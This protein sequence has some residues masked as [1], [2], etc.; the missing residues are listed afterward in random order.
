M[1][2]VCPDAQGIEPA[3][4]QPPMLL[5]ASTSAQPFGTSKGGTPSGVRPPFSPATP[6]AAELSPA[7]A[8]ASLRP[9]EPPRTSAPVDA[10]AISVAA[11]AAG[12][13]NVMPSERFG[14]CLPTKPPPSASAAAPPPSTPARLAQPTFSKLT[15][16]T[17]PSPKS[18]LLTET[19]SAAPIHVCK[20]SVAPRAAPNG[21]A[22]ELAAKMS[23]LRLSRAHADSADLSAHDDD[24]VPQAQLPATAT[25]ATP[26]PQASPAAAA[27]EVPIY[28]CDGHHHGC[29]YNG[30][31]DDVAAHEQQCVYLRLAAAPAT[32]MPAPAI[33]VIDQGDINNA[34]NTF[35]LPA[36]AASTPSSSTQ[37][38]ASTAAVATTDSAT[39]TSPA[40][41]TDLTTA[42]TTQPLQDAAP[43]VQLRSKEHK[44]RVRLHAARFGCSGS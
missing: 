7:S 29:S 22:A 35:G 44:Q 13:A 1:A 33:S 27:P 11:D 23:Q 42:A 28:Q 14:Q 41:S 10:P 25:A 37:A 36:P 12:V 21:G 30:V 3:P 9:V 5:I 19:A 18:V 17:V 8:R 40:T 6:S 16:P 2:G 31:Y 4:P 38:P 24:A 39:A 20:S 32:S 43:V 26:P 34:S 15:P